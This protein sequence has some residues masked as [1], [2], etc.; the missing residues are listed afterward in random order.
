MSSSAAHEAVSQLY[1]DV[2]P[3]LAYI[4]ALANVIALCPERG[5]SGDTVEALAVSVVHMADAMEEKLEQ[6]LASPRTWSHG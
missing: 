2:S 3:E 5:A 6:A 4:K 1:N